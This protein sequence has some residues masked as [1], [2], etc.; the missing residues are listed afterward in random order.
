[1]LRQALDG[2]CVIKRGDV[3]ETAIDA[4]GA[5]DHIQGQVE[6]GAFQ[7]EV[8]NFDLHA[9]QLQ[10]LGVASMAEIEQYLEQR[11]ML[12][13]AAQ[14][15]TVQHTLEWKI[16]L[17]QGYAA[18]VAQ[19]ATQVAGRELW[20]ESGTIDLGVDEE[21][22]NVL[23]LGV[24]AG[25]VRHTNGKVALAAVTRQQDLPGAQQ[26]HEGRAA[27]QAAEFAHRCRKG[28]WQANIV[29]RRLQTRRGATCAI[30]GQFK[31]GYVLAQILTPIRQPL[32]GPRP[33][34]MLA[35]PGGIIRVV[36]RQT[37]QGPVIATQCRCIGFAQIGNQQRV[38]P[39]I[40]NDMVQAQQQY[41]AVLVNHQAGPQQ[42]RLAQVE[43][44][45]DT[46]AQLRVQVS[47]GGQIHAFK[48]HIHDWLDDLHGL[49]IHDHKAGPQAGMAL[50]EAAQRGFQCRHIRLALNAQRPCRVIGGTVC[51]VLLKKPQPALRERQCC[52]PCLGTSARPGECGR[53]LL[54]K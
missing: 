34:K 30:A 49:V 7:L 25:G 31:H 54:I 8:Q 16:P 23:H 35:L 45:G 20:F 14:V 37:G 15:N 19:A 9:R 5:G 26:Q 44:H 46:L 32:G 21:P 41:R 6:A 50:D 51:I 29:A 48:V 28:A 11:G 39:S 40:G 52:R 47:V 42:R 22:D 18:L 10:S 24:A 17:I 38:G 27:L 33:G 36:R 12:Q 13:V 53:H 43:R 3:L 1:M 2:H 4:I